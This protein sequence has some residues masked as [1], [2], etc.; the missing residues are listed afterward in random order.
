MN[1]ND[2]R[3]R[4]I[5]ATQPNPVLPRPDLPEI[6]AFGTSQTTLRRVCGLIQ[7]A[8]I[9]VNGLIGL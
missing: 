1:V 5:D 6:G 9:V 7:W 3:D 2:P 8:A 4:L